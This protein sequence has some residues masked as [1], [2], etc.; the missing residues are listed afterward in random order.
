VWFGIQPT[1]FVGAAGAADRPCAGLDRLDHNSILGLSTLGWLTFG[2]LWLA[3]TW[4]VRHGMDL[5][6]KYEHSQG[7]S[8]WSPWPRF[9]GWIFLK[10]GASIAWSPN[11]ALTGAAMWGRYSP[12]LLF[13]YRSTQ[14][15]CSTSATSTRGCKTRRSIVGGNFWGIP[16]N[17]LFFGVIVVVMA[18]AQFKDRR[19]DHARAQRTSCTPSPTL[20]SSSPRHS[21]C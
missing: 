9:A 21:R 8:S 17:V 4:L 2:L 11:N 16:V 12:V 18:G 10:A 14:R 19:Q 15:S 20:S 7:R 3:Q 13:G 1:G 6:R 5:I